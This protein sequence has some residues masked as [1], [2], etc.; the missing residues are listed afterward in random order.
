M[1]ESSESRKRQLYLV[2]LISLIDLFSVSLVIPIL[3]T[4][5]LSLGISHV[6]IGLL[7]SVYSF[8][9]LLSGPCI[10]S[11]SDVSG[12]KNVLVLSL[13]ICS[14]CYLLL[15]YSTAFIFILLSRFILGIIKS[16]QILCKTIIADITPPSQQLEAYGLFTSITSLGFV[17]GPSFGGHIAELENGFMYVCSITSFLFIVNSL[18]VIFFV[19]NS[20]ENLKVQNSNA[21]VIEQVKLTC[22]KLISIKWEKHYPVFLVRF[23]IGV[24]VFM[25]F[26][27][28]TSY[29][30]ETFEMS[31]STIGYTVSFQGF[32]SAAAG[33]A[34]K[35][36]HIAESSIVRCYYLLILLSISFFFLTF[37]HSFSLFMFFLVPLFVSHSL[38]RVVTIEMVFEN[39]DSSERGSLNGAFN[40]VMSVA[41]LITPLISG[42]VIDSYGYKAVLF[43]SFL[44]CGLAAIFCKSVCKNKIQSKIE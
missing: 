40:S 3:S 9:Q 1:S 22:M 4:H 21:S 19:K 34:F 36:V 33:F 39:S 23:L 37:V 35:Y 2:Y 6:Q 11:W 14:A 38:L 31:P 43:I 24:S 32:I 7:G 27:N 28:Y 12:R 20:K 13:F 29:M 8:M 17:I 10:G 5:L 42:F 26:S 44:L 30:K 16:T 41:K 18:I 25:F 15:G